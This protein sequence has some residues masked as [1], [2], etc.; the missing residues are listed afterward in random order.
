MVQLKFSTLII[1]LGFVAI[2]GFFLTMILYMI[3]SGYMENRKEEK[4]FKEKR[5]NEMQS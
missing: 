1:L 2:N 5:K 4:E 3:I